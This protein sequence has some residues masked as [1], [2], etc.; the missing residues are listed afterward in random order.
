MQFRIITL[1]TYAGESAETQRTTQAQ[2]KKRR[3]EEEDTDVRRKQSKKKRR[4]VPTNKGTKTYIIKRYLKLILIRKEVIIYVCTGRSS[5]VETRKSRATTD[6]SDSESSG[7]PKHLESEA[8]K[9]KRAKQAR[10]QLRR[11]KESNDRMVR[12]RE[13]SKSKRIKKQEER[14]AKEQRNSQKRKNPKR[15]Q[16]EEPNRR[17]EGIHIREETRR[18]WGLGRARSSPDSTDVSSGDEEDSDFKSTWDLLLPIW[19]IEDR[20]EAMLHKATVNKMTLADAF[21]YQQ[22]YEQQAKKDGK[23]EA[24]FGKDKKLP[25]K[26]YDSDDKRILL[27]GA[28]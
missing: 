23:G 5:S 26:H 28:A 13:K 15:R 10:E 12:R 21:A 2:G 22:R 17:A 20:P 3:R 19:D 18:R 8:A 4:E 16:Q 11:E 24:L 25:K 14:E 1:C 27:L 7:D 6:E 9:K